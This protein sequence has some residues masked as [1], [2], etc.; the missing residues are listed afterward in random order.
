[1]RLI[2]TYGSPFVRRV[3]ATLHLYG[4]PFDHAPLMTGDDRAE[5]TALSPLGR[6]PALVLDDGSALFDS[7][8]ILDHLDEGA[9]DAALTPRFGPD[10]RRVLALTALGHGIAE[11]YVAAWYETAMRPETHVWQ[12]WLARLQDQI[13]QGLT[14]LEAALTGP[15]LAL[16]RLTQADVTAICALDGVLIDM[17][18]LIA[19]DAIPKLCALRDRLAPLDAFRLT[20][21][22]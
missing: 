14:A 4:L 8:A 16:D 7:T 15:Y 17:P 9:G 13:V 2:G 6:I 18:G 21:P 22:E 3:G 19:R 11:K 20:S 1:M 5:I 10:R 12:P